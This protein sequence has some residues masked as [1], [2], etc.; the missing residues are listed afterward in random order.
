MMVEIS[1][2]SIED[3]VDTLWMG[4]LVLEQRVELIP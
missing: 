1:G 3:G 2:T 4:E